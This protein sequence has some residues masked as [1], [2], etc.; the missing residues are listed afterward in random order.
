MAAVESQAMTGTCLTHLVDHLEQ[1]ATAVAP[2]EASVPGSV[3]TP[4]TTVPPVAK[5]APSGS[6]FDGELRTELL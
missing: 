5:E 6:W 1:A 2:A 4:S 3:A